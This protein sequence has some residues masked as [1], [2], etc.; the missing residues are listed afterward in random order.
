[1]LADEIK[2]LARLFGVTME[3]WRITEDRSQRV[4]MVLYDRRRSGNG[5]VMVGNT[6]VGSISHQCVATSGQYGIRLCI[7]SY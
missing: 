1:M 5:P 6:R 7:G 2:G 3:M 4:E